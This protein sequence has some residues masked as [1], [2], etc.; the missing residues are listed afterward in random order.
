MATPEAEAGPEPG[1]AGVADAAPDGGPRPP[2]GFCA[3]RTPK[4]RFCDDFDDG[5]VDDDWDVQTVLNGQPS[6]DTAAAKS[7]P[8]SF[9]V[10]TVALGNAE[11]AHVHLRATSSGAPAGH[12]VLAFDLKLGTAPLTKGAVAIA[13]LDVSL[14]HFFTLYL[15]DGHPDA[16][17]ATLEETAPGGTTRH[18]LSKPPPAGVWTRVTIDVDVGGARASVLWDSE[19]ALDQAT[20]APGGASDPTIRVGA[21]YVYGPADAFEA[22]FDDVTLD[23]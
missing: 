17:A 1:D 3:K 13:T 6:L 22:R 23:F 10:E 7:P 9:L 11:S 15:R 19:K 5:D 8:A 14:S 12:V 2:K 4:P 18:V 20:I 16:P 21:V